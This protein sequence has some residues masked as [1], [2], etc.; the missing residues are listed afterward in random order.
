M[1]ISSIYKYFKVV[2]LAISFEQNPV[3]T[4]FV[5]LLSRGMVITLESL[6]PVPSSHIEPCFQT[7][8]RPLNSYDHS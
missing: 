3:M 2:I 5:L 7:R 6:V 1:Y 8:W 4:L